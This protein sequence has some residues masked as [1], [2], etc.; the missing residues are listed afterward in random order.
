M[1]SQGLMSYGKNEVNGSR[2]L[3]LAI[4]LNETLFE[5]VFKLGFPEASPQAGSMILFDLP[6]LKVT[7]VFG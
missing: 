4:F 2:L 1:T 5:K 3:A 7:S 6:I